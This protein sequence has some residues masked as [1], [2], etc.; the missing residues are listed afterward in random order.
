MISFGYRKNFT[1]LLSAESEFY[2]RE[3]L[4]MVYTSEQIS[5]IWA[6][7]SVNKCFIIQ[8]PRET[9]KRLS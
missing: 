2:T 1:M 9:N 7:L 8:L 5:L 4:F 3:Y 6:E